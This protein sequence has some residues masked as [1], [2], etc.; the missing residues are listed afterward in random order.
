MCVIIEEE[1]EKRNYSAIST[2]PNPKLRGGGRWGG[3]RCVADAAERQRT[4]P[5]WDEAAPRWA[6]VTRLCCVSSAAICSFCSEELFLLKRSALNSRADLIRANWPW[7]TFRQ[8]YVLA[9]D[10]ESFGCA[11]GK[12]Q[13]KTKKK[14]HMLH[15]PLPLMCRKYQRST[16]SFSWCLLCRPFWAPDA[17]SCPCLPTFVS[18]QSHFYCRLE[19]DG[20]KLK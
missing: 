3:S 14:T 1:R 4:P 13:K 2:Q 8:H 17:P 19:A 6:T 20:A 7:R 10:F 18:Q 12:K 5:R 15:P 11:N 9:K 16:H